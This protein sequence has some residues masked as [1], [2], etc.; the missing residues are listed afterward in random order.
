MKRTTFYLWMHGL[1]CL[2]ASACHSA[3]SSND[4][5]DLSHSRIGVLLGSSQ[6]HYA[7]QAFPSARLLRIDMSS[8]L[9]MALKSG[10]CDAVLFSSFTAIPILQ[11]EPSL[12]LLE[13][14]DDVGHLGIGFRKEDE[15]LCQQF[16][17]F[18]QEL[19]QSDT[20]TDMYRRWLQG[21]A[22]QA[23]V[24]PL[25]SAVQGQPLRVGT[26]LM[27]VPFSHTQDNRPAG[28]DI[29]LTTR[30]ASYLH[31]PIE[32]V[33]MNFGS[34]IPALQ[35]GQVDLIANNIMMTEERSKAIRFSDSYIDDPTVVLVLRKEQPSKPL[36]THISQ[37]GGQKVGVLTGSIH[38]GFLR[39]NHPDVEAFCMDAQSDLLQGLLTHKCQ[40][41]ISPNDDMREPIQKHPQITLL[42]DSLMIEK[43]V[44][45]IHP[46]N[47]Q[48][49]QQF[50]AFLKEL[51]E[52]GTL[53]DIIRRYLS[54]VPELQMPDIPLPTQGTPLRVGSMGGS[55]PWT[56][57]QNGE[58]AGF[59]MEMA[60]RFAAYLNRP[61]EVN[62]INFSGLIAALKSGK[63]DLIISQIAYTP[64]RAQ[65]ISL[66]D[67]YYQI[68]TGLYGLNES[69]STASAFSLS[70]WWNDVKQSF[71]NNLVAENRYR[72]ILDGLGVTLIITLCAALLGTLLGGVVCFLRM[73]RNRWLSRTAACYV[74]L[75]RGTP[76]LVLLMLMFYVFLAPLEVSGVAVAI[77]TF[78][79]NLAAYASEMFRSAIEGIDHGQTEAGVALGFTRLQTFR[80]IILP[81]AVRTVMPVYKGELI[82]LLKTTSIVGYI[83]VVDLTKA[84]DII[85]ARTFDAFFPLLLV[86]AIYFVVAWLMG[87]LLDLTISS[88]KK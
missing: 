1:L 57:V 62:D 13:E 56:F 45:G 20:Y 46:D 70:G 63:V 60:R 34:L 58:Y 32:F 15:Q 43:L 44:A 59:D 7:T 61:I 12:Q 66:S 18:L 83:A 64:E 48:L 29:E 10:S 68:V 73:H 79:L 14:M 17:T 33:P 80:Y 2:L 39:Q 26:T 23:T 81:Q 24:P 19:K 3:P 76:V 52:S 31:R 65:S 75:M 49:L 85:R 55:L 77:V 40:A 86:A 84:S 54:P 67:S 35:T 69:Q 53:D 47:G 25:E 74:S 78:G 87:K 30:F 9:I 21:N 27:S 72:Q 38:E 82:S 6:D 51:K 11:S 8:D 88:R 5:L 41:I 71:H 22:E 4:V 42:Q 50:N 37:L 28:Y 36:A 16:N